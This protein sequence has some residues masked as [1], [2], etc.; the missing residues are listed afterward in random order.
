MKKLAL[1]GL[2]VA[3]GIIFVSPASAFFG[4]F[5]GGKAASCCAPA[6]CAPVYCAPMICAPVCAPAYCAPAPC[7]V[8]KKGKKVKKAK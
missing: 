4:L 3:L 1:V 5:G 7:K 8:Y 2:V 6:Y